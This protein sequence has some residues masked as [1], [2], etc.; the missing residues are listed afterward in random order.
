VVSFRE[1]VA[2][3][4]A[5]HAVCA[6]LYGI[7]ILS[8]SLDPPNLHRGPTAADHEYLTTLCLAGIAAEEY[9]FGVPIPDPAAIQQDLNMARECVARSIANPLQAAIELARCKVAAERLVHSAWAQQRIRVLAD[10]L[11]RCGT[12]SGEEIHRI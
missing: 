9:F 1:R 5:A 10:A 8:V 4:E 12:L 11:L 6:I 3:H 7:P 2:T